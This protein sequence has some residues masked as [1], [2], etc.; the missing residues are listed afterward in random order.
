MRSPLVLVLALMLA[1]PLAAQAGAGAPGGGMARIPAGSYVPLYTRGKEKTAAV[2]AFELD[3]RPVT[4]AE[5][6]EF[7]RVRPRW[8]KSAA[9]AVFAE[10]RYLADWPGDLD[11]GA[12]AELRR[13]VTYVSWF[14]ARAYCEWRGKR[15]PT[16]D[17][18]EYAAAASEEARDATRDPAFTRRLL[19]MYTARRASPAAAG[20]TF[21]NAY[22]VWDLHGGVWEWVRDFNNVLV[23]DD[24]RG[25]AA[26]DERLFCAAGAVGTSDPTNYPAFLRL[27][28]RAGLTGVTTAPNL[29]FR[30]ARSL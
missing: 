23:S 14:A 19:A 5:Y 9:P 15:L 26:R 22:G 2:A 3:R 8:R 21:R 11:A 1:S 7:V 29:G 10:G 28:F 13:P 16:A 24:S 25:T 12:G 6:A 17:E 30:C 20:T 18:W 27:A 4:R